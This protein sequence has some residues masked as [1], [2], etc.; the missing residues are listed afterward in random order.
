M[1]KILTKSLLIASLLGLTTSSYADGYTFDIDSLIGIEGGYTSFDVEND[2]LTIDK[3]IHKYNVGEV[4]LKIGAQSQNYRLFLS[5]HNYFASDYDYAVT[6]GGE[7]QY[8]F[9]FSQK[10]NFFIGINGGMLAARFVGY[11][12]L[13]SK[14]R[15]ISDPYFGGDV[16]FNYHLNKTYDLE[17]GARVMATDAKNTQTINYPSGARNVTY[18]FDNLVTGYASIIVKFQMD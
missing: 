10:A 7:F 3:G 18:T 6:Y 14:A 13:D 4:G 1:K 9:N 5:V 12:I 15:T 8:L 17:I 16:G 2:S 11:G